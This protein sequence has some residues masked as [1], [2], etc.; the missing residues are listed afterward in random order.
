MWH[1]SLNQ[2][3]VETSV[4]LYQVFF[5]L[6]IGSKWESKVVKDFN[7]SKCNFFIFILDLSGVGLLRGMYL[8]LKTCMLQ[9]QF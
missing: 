8:K 4:I 5:G 2:W 1:R 3:N 7:V 6:M 9:N